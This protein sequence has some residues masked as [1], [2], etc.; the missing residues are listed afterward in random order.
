MRIRPEVETNTEETRPTRRRCRARNHRFWFLLHPKTLNVANP[1]N[2][3]KHIDYLAPV[4]F[5]ELM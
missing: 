1:T 2:S 4:E 3:T 5:L